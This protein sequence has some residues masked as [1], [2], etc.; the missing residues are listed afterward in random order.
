M[1]EFCVAV[2]G[3]LGLVGQEMLRVLEQRKFPVSK[4]KALDVPANSGKLVRFGGAAVAVEAAEEDVFADVD[5]ALFSAGAEAS[6]KLAPLA[7]QKGCVVIDNSSAWRM[8]PDCPLVVPEVNPKDLRR[9]RGIIANPNCSTIQMVVALKPLHDAFHIKRIVVSTYQAVSGGGKRAL[10][11]LTRQTRA[12][13]DGEPIRAEVFPHQIAFNVLPQVD[14]FLENGYTKE[15]MKLVDETHKILDP[16]IK[17]CPTAVRV[18]V[19]RGHSESIAIETDLP[20]D[21][22]KARELLAHFPGIGLMDDV[23][24]AVYPHPAAADGQD[25]TYV[26]R[27]RTDPTVPNGMCL[28]VVSDNLRKGAALNAVQIAE[29]MAAMGLIQPKN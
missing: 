7:A 4:I 5:I 26:G 20:I 9:H 13:L 25:L 15:E 23:G 19:I 8:H 14:V 11:E 28:W 24:H 21:L 18:P 1:T 17:V 3:A 12:Y 10:E 29:T 2:V 6:L 22:E 27:L 16:D